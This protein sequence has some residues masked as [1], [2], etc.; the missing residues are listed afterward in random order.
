MTRTPTFPKSGGYVVFEMP[1]GAAKKLD[2]GSPR[3]DEAVRAQRFAS[4]ADVETEASSA[5]WVTASDPSGHAIQFD[6]YNAGK[7][8]A[9]LQVRSDTKKL[10]AQLLAL[11]VKEEE[12]TKGGK[13]DKGERAAVRE[14]LL[15]RH[16]PTLPPKSKF[17]NVLIRSKQRTVMLFSTNRAAHE[18]F[19]QLFEETFG[20]GLVL[21]GEKRLAENCLRGGS[22]AALKKLEPTKWPKAIGGQS[23]FEL[24]TTYEWLGEEFLVWLLFQSKTNG[25]SIDASKSAEIGVVPDDMIATAQRRVEGTRQV[26][27]DGRVIDSP[28][29]RA[30]IRACDS[31]TALS[32]FVGLEDGNYSVSIQAAGVAVTSAQLPEEQDAYEGPDERNEDRVRSWIALDTLLQLLFARFMVERLDKWDTATAPR[33]TAWMRNQP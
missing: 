27:R 16:M 28:C 20:I 22:R 24:D 26:I 25:G 30:S 3:F 12:R 6:E 8:V 4:I 2:V 13:L 7:G 11:A 18:A 9:W 23:E 14:A 21:R 15:K 31:I 33:I 17:V 29:A 19:P 1:A 5:G 10:P 32:L